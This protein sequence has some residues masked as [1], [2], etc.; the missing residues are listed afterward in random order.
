MHK[1]CYLI[2][3]YSPVVLL[4]VRAILAVALS[5]VNRAVFGFVSPMLTARESPSSGEQGISQ[6]SDPPRD[7][8]L[9]VVPLPFYSFGWGC[10]NMHIMCD[11]S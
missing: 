5:K 2:R 7:I 10:P 3:K 6:S 8:N 4:G 11:S 9:R 1:V